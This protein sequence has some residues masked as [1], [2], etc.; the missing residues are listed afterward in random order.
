[1]RVRPA[2]YR[3]KRIT[4]AGVATLQ[5]RCGRTMEV[6]LAHLA[7]CHLANIDPAVDVT[8]QTPDAD[9]A[10]EVCR[11][12]HDAAD[13]LLCDECSAGWHNYCLVPEVLGVPDGVWI[14]PRCEAI[15]VTV[16]GVRARLEAAPPAAEGPAEVDTGTAGR[17]KIARVAAQAAAAKRLDGRL[18]ERKFKNPA[19]GRG[20]LYRGVLVYQ[21]AES[22]PNYFVAEFEDGDKHP[23][24][25]AMAQRYLLPAGEEMP[26]LAAA[27]VEVQQL[28]ADSCVLPSLQHLMPG[29]WPACRVAG[30]AAALAQSIVVPGVP[31]AEVAFLQS[32]LLLSWCP[33]RWDPCAD[34]S[35][36]SSVAHSRL[37][38]D[39]DA[40]VTCP[41][42]PILDLILPL[43][44]QAPAVVACLRVPCTYLSDGPPPRFQYLRR[45]QAQ[46]RLVVL[47]PPPAAASDG[48]RWAWVVV[49]KSA[50]VRRAMLVPGC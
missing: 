26:A 25:L 39:V 43:C 27:A 3:I 14:C 16:E 34:A 33:Y 13:M 38:L 23:T 17:R 49:F 35:P 8:L 4:A 37:H 41:Y 42:E 45:L 31:D 9:L 50:A 1:M 10:C 40:I 15:G 48:Q 24:T 36:A 7:A 2:I 32:R 18:V 44:V 47:Y 22:G 12:T 20:R 5:G 28:A 46:D 19:T 21:G 30:V 29:A 6:H 11:H